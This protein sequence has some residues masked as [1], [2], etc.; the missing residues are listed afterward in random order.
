MRMDWLILFAVAFALAVGFSV[1]A[2][3]WQPKGDSDFVEDI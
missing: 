1:A 3:A 2:L